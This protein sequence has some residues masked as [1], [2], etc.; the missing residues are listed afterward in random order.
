MAGDEPL[1]TDAVAS[2]F[3]RLSAAMHPD[4]PVS[5]TRPHPSARWLDRA[6]EGLIGLGALVVLVSIY[7][8]LW[9]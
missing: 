7:A 2:A 1:P 3:A 6:V 5:E 4:T 8:M 9:L